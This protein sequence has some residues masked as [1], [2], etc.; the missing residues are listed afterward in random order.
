MTFWLPQASTSAPEVDYLIIGL[1]LSTGA[2]LALVFGLIV[3][4]MIKY[5]VGSKVDRGALLEKTWRL[6]ITWTTATLVIFFGLFIWGANLYL[7]LFRPPSNA[8][9]IFVVGKQWMWKAEHEGGQREI[10]ALH[11]PV[12]RTIQLVMTSEDVIHDFS[13][14]A[15]R[16]KHDVLPGRYESLWFEAT[17]PGTYH[18]FCTQLCGTGHAQMTGELVAMP[19]ADYMNWL[20]VNS[21]TGSLAAEG[22]ILFM[23]FGCSG[24]H[25]GNGVGGS[26]SGSTV[27]A[28]ALAGLYGSPVTLVNGEVVTADD[29]YIR[30][31]IL[32]PEK[33]RVASYPPVMPSFS[34]VISEDDVLKLI[35]YIKSLAP[36]NRQ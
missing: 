32:L 17:R 25:G 11:I 5:R 31:C 14:P 33:R 13:V 34:K 26:Q 1:L 12:G 9:Q 30:D 8:L 3:L 7:R 27:R 2:V 6:E 35:A 28:P 36:E 10:N 22:K 20:A 21:T 15:F 23:R 18:L 24:C 29:A 4:Y 19:E 16:I